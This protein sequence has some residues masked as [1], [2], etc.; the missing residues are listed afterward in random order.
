M[1]TRLFL[2]IR[3]IKI[4]KTA[5]ADVAA[6]AGCAIA[7]GCGIINNTLDAAKNSSVIVFGVGGIGLS[8]ILGA[9]NRGCSKIIAVDVLDSKLNFAKKLGATHLINA[10]RSSVLKNISAILPDGADYAVDASG[11]KTAME[12][13]FASI[14]N[15]GVCVIAGNLGKE[16][17]I[18]LHPF[19]LI[20]GK[21]IIGTWG[22][23]TDPDRD[24]PSYLKAFSRGV[25]PIDR[26][27]THQFSLEDINKAFEVLVKGE[28]G[29]IILKMDYEK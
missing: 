12:N 14:K 18:E 29:R 11:S 2:K 6:I 28:A 23:E 17:K 16:E 22:G 4:P 1:I 8:V 9:R 15:T 26:M 21:R 20:K 5:P 25:L 3:V 13:A 24:I 10:S 19:E 27:I 7:T